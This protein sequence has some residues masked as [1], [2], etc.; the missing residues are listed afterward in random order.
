MIFNR[1]SSLKIKLKKYFL[2]KSA[3]KLL[4][5]ILEHPVHWEL[6]YIYSES[7]E[8]RIALFRMIKF[9]IV[10]DL[11]LEVKTIE[12]VES[13][14]LFNIMKNNCVTNCLRGDEYFCRELFAISK[15]IKIP[16]DVE[17]LEKILNILVFA[18][19]KENLQDRKSVYVK[20]YHHHGMSGG[21]VSSEN[22]SK[23]LL[24]MI[25]YYTNNF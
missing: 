7:S 6:H 16:N 15:F 8:F 10:N 9:L 2:K 4:K 19:I 20:R 25:Y 22:W 11:Y 12:E 18:L 1:I 23:N 24:Y 17:E 21:H 5:K 14:S 13:L 3:L